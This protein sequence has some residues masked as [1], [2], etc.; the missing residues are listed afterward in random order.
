MFLMEEESSCW[1]RA[2][3]NPAQPALVKFY[4]SSPP[5]LY[6]TY[7]YLKTLIKILNVILFDTSLSPSSLSPLHFLTGCLR[8]AVDHARKSPTTDT[9]KWV[10]RCSH[11]KRTEIATTALNVDQPIVSCAAQNVSPKHGFTTE[12]F[13]VF[14]QTRVADPAKSLTGNFRKEPLDWLIRRISSPPS[15]KQLFQ[16]LVVDVLLPSTLCVVLL[17]MRWNNLLLWRAQLALVAVWISAALLSL[18]SH[19]QKEKLE[20]SHSLV[21]MRFL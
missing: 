20:V 7:Y 16:S 1:C 5:Q 15:A 18:K 11:G 3:C 6:V 10:H 19:A 12:T 2:C 8:L 4:N 14:V 21:L 9:T 17:T 13:Q